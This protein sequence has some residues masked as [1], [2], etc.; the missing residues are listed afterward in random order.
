MQDDG[1]HFQ[2]MQVTMNVTVNPSSQ[3]TETASASTLNETES[4]PSDLG[5]HVMIHISGQPPCHRTCSRLDGIEN[6][7]APGAVD[8]R[9]VN[10]PRAGN[11]YAP[12]RIL[13]SDRPRHRGAV[14]STQEETIGHWR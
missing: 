5:W 8:K 9:L 4:H 6:M 13:H 11:L 12:F 2:Q 7:S 1:D 3:S 14:H 10:A